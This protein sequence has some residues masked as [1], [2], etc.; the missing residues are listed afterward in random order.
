VSV[1]AF[2]ASDEARFITGQLAQV[3]SMRAFQEPTTKEE[4]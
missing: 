1:I 3:P 2:G 4:S